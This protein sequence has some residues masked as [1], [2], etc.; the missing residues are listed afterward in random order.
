MISK[1]LLENMK[2][3]YSWVTILYPL[4]TLIQD[5]IL[6]II[7]I[8]LQNY[9]L[10]RL[11]ISLFYYSTNATYLLYDRPLNSANRNI[12]EIYSSFCYLIILFLFF[13]VNSLEGKLSYHSKMVYLGYPIIITL[14]LALIGNFMISI[15]ILILKMIIYLRK[16]SC[17]RKVEEV[18][19][20][21]K[22]RNEKINNLPK[23]NIE[24][25]KINALNR[26]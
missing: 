11:I 17:L 22:N 10:F 26:V 24:K 7:L 13:L 16:Y 23:I 4:F 21:T 5:F 6:S 14:I 12:L 18:K 15:I 25:K 3:K 2:E 8:Y 20:P 19:G 1:A 9:P